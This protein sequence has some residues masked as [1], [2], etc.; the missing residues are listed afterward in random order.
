M[1]GCDHGEF[2]ST[3]PVP[4]ISVMGVIPQWGTADR[5]EAVATG[6]I[7]VFVEREIQVLG[8]GFRE[9]VLTPVTSEADLIERVG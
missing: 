8:A 9:H 3:E 1:V 5:G 2:V 7:E 4:Q 6:L